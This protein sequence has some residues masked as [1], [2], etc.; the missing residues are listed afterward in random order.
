MPDSRWPIA[1]RRSRAYVAAIS[2][3][4]LQRS[5]RKRATS[6]EVLAD[7]A[8]RAARSSAGWHWCASS[9]GSGRRRAEQDRGAPGRGSVPTLGQIEQRREQERT[10]TGGCRT[11]R[12]SRSDRGSC[13]RAAPRAS[14]SATRSLKCRRSTRRQDEEAGDGPGQAGQARG[15]LVVERE[16]V[17]DRLVQRVSAWAA[18]KNG[19]CIIATPIGWAFTHRPCAATGRSR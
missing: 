18:R 12:R 10:S 9:G 14:R 16:A 7:S 2:A 3:S 13:Q 19:A 1:A 11:S 4:S 6:G 15:V 17:G 5:R 8:R